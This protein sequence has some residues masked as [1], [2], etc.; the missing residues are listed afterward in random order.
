MAFLRLG[1][2]RPTPPAQKCLV[3]ALKRHAF[4]Y[5]TDRGTLLSL[6]GATYS[7]LTLSISFGYSVLYQ[8]CPY[9]RRKQITK[10]GSIYT[11]RSST[12]TPVRDSHIIIIICYYK[13]FIPGFPVNSSVNAVKP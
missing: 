11:R 7:T 3:P 5:G 4:A 2:K 10:E 9:A 6:T 12:H 8:P 13:L 1:V